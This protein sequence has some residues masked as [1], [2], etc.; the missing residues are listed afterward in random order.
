M[1][2][3]ETTRELVRIA[4]VN[5]GYGP[6]RAGEAGMAEWL[7][8]WAQRHSFES[9]SQPVFPGR[10]NIVLR[11]RNGSDRPHLLLNGHTDTVAVQEMTVPPFGAE[12]RDGRVWGRGSADMKGPLACMLHALLALRANPMRWEFDPAP[13]ADGPFCFEADHPIVRSVCEAAGPQADG[14]GR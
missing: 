2:V 7:Q 11:L 6:D 1:N 13:L 5:P 3:T 4:S 8:R 12:L 9:F 14:L 10:Q